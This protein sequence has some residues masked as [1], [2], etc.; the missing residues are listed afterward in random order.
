MALDLRHLSRVLEIRDEDASVRV[1]A[2]CSWAAL[3]A[4]LAARGLR[5]PFRGPAS[6]LHATIGGTLSQDAAFHGSAR[7][8][9][10][11]EGVLGLVVLLAD[12]RRPRTGAALLGDTQ[13]PA[14]F[15]PDLTQL[16]VGACGAFGMLLEATLRT[17]PWP[18]ASRS[19]GYRCA[20]RAVALGALRAAAR[21]RTTRPG[22]SASRS[23]APRKPWPMR[24]SCRSRPPASRP[25]PACSRRG[26]PSP[27]RRRA[28]CAAS[29]AAAGCQCTASCRSRAPR[30]PSTRSTRR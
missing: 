6:G 23:T 13:A 27:S 20:N 29:M 25:A 8:G 9:T 19:A 1:E 11:A 24:V 17:V 18:A 26:S 12:G 3:D 28:C 16:F 7:H 21:S 2:G 5:T 22:C 4:A 15:G 14:P 30:R 10:A